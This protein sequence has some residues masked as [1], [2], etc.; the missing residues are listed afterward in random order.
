M[1]RPIVASFVLGLSLAIVPAP[2]C[3]AQPP[4]PAKKPV[5][6][7]DDLPRHTYRIEGKASEFLLS[8]RP[9][10]EFLARV[11]A[12]VEADLAGYD[13]TDPTTLQGYH[14]VLM[15]AAMIEGRWD[16]ALAQAERIRALEQKESK[17]LMTGQVLGSMV[18]ARR[19][20]GD[21]R[22]AFE[23]AF[24]EE[25]RR[26][27]SAFPWDVVREEVTQAKGRAEMVSRALII[28]GMQGQ[29][30]PVVEASGGELSGDMARGL[31]GARAALDVILPLN[32]MVAEVYAD[33]INSRKAA[34]VD[35][36]KD[37][38]VSLA[39]SDR[40]TPVVVAIWDSGVDVAL[41]SHRLWTNPNE[42]INGRDD[43]GNGFIDDVHGIAYDLD[44]RPVPA[45]LC[46]LEEL[47][48]D[49]DLVVTHTKGLSD[50]Q[51]NVDSPERAALLTY[52]RS[53]QPDQVTAFREDLGLFGN[54]AH[55]THVAGIAAEGNPFIRLL[56]VRITF[57]YRAIPLHTPTVERARAEAKA[58]A[59]IVAYMKRA[60]V[61]VVN[62]S[63]GGSRQDIEDDL[64]KKNWG[65]SAQERA[66]QS[67]VLFRI[68]RDAM[69]EAIASA[70]EILFIAAAGNADS[71]NQF[72]EFIPSG[73]SLP[74][75]VTVGA[76]DQSGKPT[77]FTSFGDNVH[78]YAN[79][80]E[81]E[82][83]IPGGRR[84]KFSGTSMAAPQVANLAA[85][86]LA[87][88]PTLTTAQVIDLITRAG[89]PM[90]GSK[91]G[92]TRLLINPKRTL[93]LARQAK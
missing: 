44:A 34:A 64:E 63:W 73:L 79:G 20:A 57:D 93:E 76:V 32:P 77:G 23:A 58:A 84:L 17:R 91:D 61:R 29:I 53:L 28:G 8:D 88:N 72:S 55:G 82:S 38:A 78:L 75:M 85:K 66:E 13:I 37:R 36:W 46:G 19:A 87:V 11:A 49:R 30:D 56:P 5:R 89:D 24:K 47:R 51:S 33:I 35:I 40:A 6:T 54:H 45:L 65:S 15:Q 83:Y 21:D 12:D 26:R 69:Q 10:R 48:N 81:V 4:A 2:L 7:A 86:I 52:L 50:L 70:P 80:F 22:A 92:A 39:E 59:D 41:F 60:G 62:M 71:N 67:R 16:D 31:I 68:F 25:L 27:V 43:D 90:S 42:T 3:P 18:A 74:N 1:R 9:F 14:G